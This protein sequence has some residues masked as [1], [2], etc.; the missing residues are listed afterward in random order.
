M[1]FLPDAWRLPLH[2]PNHDIGEYR[3]YKTEGGEPF[4]VMRGSR[5]SGRAERTV[6]H[7]N[8]RISKWSAEVTFGEDGFVWM[9]DYTTEQ[10]LTQDGSVWKILNHPSS[11][12]PFKIGCVGRWFGE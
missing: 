4:K 10:I 8:G 2:F 1:P 9:K 12:P 5:E 3:G 6:K 11:K 7:S